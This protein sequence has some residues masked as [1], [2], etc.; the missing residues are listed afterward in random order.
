MT[1][2]YI[3]KLEGWPDLPGAARIAAEVRYAAELDRILGHVDSIEAVWSEHQALMEE[4]ER[5]AAHK[6]PKWPETRWDFAMKRATSAG[7]FGLVL[8]YGARFVLETTWDRFRF[9]MPNSYFAQLDGAPG[10]KSSAV[11]PAH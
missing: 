6:P 4:Y 3:V 10:G 11:S 7:A 8:P 1:K 5:A 2:P 9:D